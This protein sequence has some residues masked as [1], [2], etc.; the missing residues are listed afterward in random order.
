MTS[1]VVMEDSIFSELARPHSENRDNLSAKDTLQ[2]QTFP[3][4]SDK[5]TKWLA[6]KCPLSTGMYSA[7]INLLVNISFLAF[8]LVPS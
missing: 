6:P 7:C 3:L 2:K 5:R 8:V 1:P 4:T